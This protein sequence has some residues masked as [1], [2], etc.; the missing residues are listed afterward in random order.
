VALAAIARWDPALLPVGPSTRLS[1]VAAAV[2]D[3]LQPDYQCRGVVRRAP[4]FWS[5]AT[6]DSG[7]ALSCQTA[8]GVLGLPPRHQAAAQFALVR[9]RVCSRV[10]PG[11]ERPPG[12]GLRDGG[13]GRMGRRFAGADSGSGA[14]IAAGPHRG[15]AAGTGGEPAS[16]SLNFT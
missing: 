14:D 9:G 4:R 2:A 11:R 5:N 3:G 16:V 6:H 13:P 8:G 7:H 12:P 1:V 10:D 15:F